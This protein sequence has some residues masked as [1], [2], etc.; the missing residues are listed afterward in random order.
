[1]ILDRETSPKG[2]VRDWLDARAETEAIAIVF[3]ETEDT[4]TWRALRDEACA[5]AEALIAL[6]A[7]RGESVAIV[8]PNGRDGVVA[9][10]RP[11][12]GLRAT[13]INLAAGPDAIAYAL[14]HSEALA[15]VHDNQRDV[16]A[17]IAPKLRVVDP[18]MLDNV[19]S[20]QLGLST[21]ASDVP[22]RND[23]SAQGWSIPC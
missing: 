7:E 14:D 15:F 6:G 20:F 11:C 4:L 13:M 9:L 8:H 23:R 18:D 17:E 22:I 1:M 5:K 2:T 12:M 19:Q 21:M 3:P 16:I 10:L